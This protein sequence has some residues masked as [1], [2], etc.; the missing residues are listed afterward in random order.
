MGEGRKKVKGVERW[1]GEENGKGT[2]EKSKQGREREQ[3][4]KKEGKERN[5]RG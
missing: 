4:E 1:E 3:G 2:R 5:R